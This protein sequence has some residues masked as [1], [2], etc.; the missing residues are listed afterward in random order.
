MVIKLTWLLGKCMRKLNPLMKHILESY[1]RRCFKVTTVRFVHPVLGLHQFQ[2]LPI[3]QVLLLN[4]FTST[5]TDIDTWKHY[6]ICS[7]N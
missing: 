6:R 5:S 2:I 4:V 7:H 1:T 3:I